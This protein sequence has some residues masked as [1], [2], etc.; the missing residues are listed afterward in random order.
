M[1]NTSTEVSQ[2]IVTPGATTTGT[3][4]NYQI[5]FSL[6]RLGRLKPNESTITVT[7][8]SAYTLNSSNLVYD[9]TQISVD[10]GSYTTIPT[11]NITPN[12]TAKT[13]Q[14]T[15]PQS[16]ITQNS[17]NEQLILRQLI[18]LSRELI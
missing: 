14:I 10:G 11:A 9:N 18:S 4:T 7:F 2:A 17:D 16:V 12:N 15:I 5:D 1:F 13:V 8:N 3:A 6:G